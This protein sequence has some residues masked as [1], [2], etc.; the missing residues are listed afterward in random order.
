MKSRREVELWDVVLLGERL[1]VAPIL[2]GEISA[3]I[4]SEKER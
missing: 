4:V 3:R 1:I 2:V